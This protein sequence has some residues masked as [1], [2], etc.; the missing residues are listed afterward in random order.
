VRSD[1]DEA[2]LAVLVSQPYVVEILDLLRREPLTQRQ[3]GRTLPR[4]RLT[5][6][7]RALAAH[8]AIRRRDRHGSWDHLVP[9]TYELTTIGRETV[10]L[11]EQADTWDA[12]YQRY[13]GGR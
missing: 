1:P 4:R 7:L 6:A 13:L 5:R 11:L 10:A 2:A 3:L 9:A 8:G 12:L